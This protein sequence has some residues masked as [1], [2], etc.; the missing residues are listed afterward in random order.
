MTEHTPGPWE[1]SSGMMN[2]GRPNIL[3]PHKDIH[4][5]IT[6]LEDES[7][8]E[9]WANAHL[10]SAA[11]DMHEALKGLLKAFDEEDYYNDTLLD[12][13]RAALAKAEGE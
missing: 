7:V 4:I 12:R 6:F 3:L 9:A 5:S 8:Y 11:P 10:V 1:V 2:M 13:A